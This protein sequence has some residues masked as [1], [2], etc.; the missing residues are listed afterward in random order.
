M[1]KT[2]NNW[3]WHPFA[4]HTIIAAVT[5]AVMLAVCWLFSVVSIPPVL[6]AVT[7]PFVFFGSRAEREIEDKLETK[8]MKDELAF[9]SGFNPRSWA[10]YPMQIGCFLFPALLCVV[11]L[12]AFILL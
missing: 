2:W 4:E 10:P 1:F 9:A 11:V 6:W 8:G 5:I 12:V 3:K 7:V